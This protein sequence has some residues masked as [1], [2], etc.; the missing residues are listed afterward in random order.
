MEKKRYRNGITG[1]TFIIDARNNCKCNCQNGECC[2]RQPPR[3]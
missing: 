2:H 1:S 3:R